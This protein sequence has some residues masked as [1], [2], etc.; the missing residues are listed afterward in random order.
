MGKTELHIIVEIFSCP[1]DT[2]NLRLYLLLLRDIYLPK[3]MRIPERKRL[4]VI[5]IT[6]SYLRDFLALNI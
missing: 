2:E 1:Q 5:K 3:T 6:E 4:C